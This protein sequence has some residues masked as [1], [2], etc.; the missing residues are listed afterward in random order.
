MYE[1]LF[2]G[3]SAKWIMISIRSGLDLKREA[4]VQLTGR[5]L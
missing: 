3:A 2:T 5:L 4:R 1:R